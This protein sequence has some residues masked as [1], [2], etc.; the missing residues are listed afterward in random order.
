MSS[1]PSGTV[2]FLFTDIE[3]STKLAQEHSDKWE[4][5]HERHHAILKSAIEI[6]NGYVFQIIGDAFCA[7]FHN[8]YDGLSTA[9]QAQQEL[10]I[11]NWGD[12]SIRVRMGLHTGSAE[13]RGSEYQGYLTLARVQRVM[14][15]AHG[16]QILLSN[17]SVQLIHNEL[18]EGISLRD[19]KEHHLKGLLTPEHLWQVIARNLQKDFPALR[20]LNEIPNNLPVHLTS[21]IGR[22]KEIAELKRELRD[23]RIITLT[24]SGGTGKTRLCLQVAA[25]VIDSFPDGV[26]LLELAPITDP[27]LVPYALANLLGL[28]ESAA[29]NHTIAELVS[30]YFHSRT[31][32]VVFDNCEHLIEACA[33]L[34]DL[35]LHSCKDLR[36][37]ASSRESLGIEGEMAWHVPSLSL[38]DMRQLP[39][40]EGLSQYEAVQLFVERATLVQPH[41]AVTKDN[42]STIAQICFRLDGIPLAI[43]LAAA[44]VNV[45]TLVQ[46]ARRLDDRFRLLTGGARTALPRQQTLQALIDWSYNLLS[47]QERLLFRR[48]AVFVGGWTL[49]AAETVCG[50][51]GDVPDG[52]IEP[53]QILDLL[54]Q[55]VKKSLVTMQDDHGASRYHRLE[56]IR[57][58][59]REKLFETEE[60]AHLR[61]K[62]LDYFLQLAEQGFE[63]LNGPNDLVWIEKL[64]AEHDNFRTALSWSLES[65]DV[66]PQKALQLSGAL[67]DFWDMRGYTS[68]GY[69]WLSKSLQK[70][71]DAPTYEH[72]RALVGIGLLCM[73]LS[74]GK[75]SLMHLDNA[76]NLARQLDSVTL[77]LRCSYYLAYTPFE[78]QVDRAK[79]FCEEGM[80]LAR[81][82]HDSYYLGMLLAQWANF[83]DTTPD[84]I[85]ALAEA[86]EIAARL[87]NARLRAF[88]LWYYGG[89]EM[90]RARY[91]SAT[92]MLQEALSLSQSLKDK[93]QTAWCLQSLGKTAT[94]QTLYD[95]ATRFEAESV[96]ILRDMSDRHCAA[97]SL[98][99][100]GWN[101]FLSGKTSQAIEHLEECLRIFREIEDPYIFTPLVFLGRV[102]TS[103]GN[104]QKAKEYFLEG[105]G[106]MK[107][108][109]EGTYWLARCLEGMC[110]L[111]GI[112]PDKAA[113]LLGKA[114]AI[115]EKEAFV[116]P[117]SE[118]PLIEPTLERLQSQLGK[119]ILDSARAAGAM[120]TDEQAIDEAIDILNVID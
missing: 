72:C 2:T 65:P 60:A 36:I 29:A 46:I 23:H 10:Q 93:H 82:K 90:E 38:P 44:R 74:R 64:E 119:E 77:I 32:L 35:L 53:H 79:R 104:I 87:G 34:A 95:D 98:L 42:A 37:L 91:E 58:Y 50:G 55:L 99:W 107:K 81:A 92:S 47:E 1:L 24:G 120:L 4:T 106:L 9:I 102:F 54:S 21:F 76:L 110:A 26:W 84:I 40:M 116:L 28:R 103:Q 111:P 96:Q 62:H 70:A 18:P 17:A 63:E 117:L 97:L 11:E 48:L 89:F 101:A 49:E 86:H 27:A 83:S 22:E 41:F 14:S 6:N 5:L 19:M 78:S 67:Q 57:Q 85:R 31:A 39:A 73:R 118:Q 7:A 45:L 94:Q 43:E 59:A 12:A 20:S 69:Q 115:R 88:V 80:A 51:K 33:R 109:S 16:G 52:G 100:L 112:Q 25:A 8:V 13:I 3:G 66:D 15:V 108:Y 75:D 114:E 113:R 105:L 61:D 56:T 68:E 30:S 71:P